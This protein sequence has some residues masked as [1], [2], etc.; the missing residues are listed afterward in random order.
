[1][2]RVTFS[3]VTLILQLS[4]AKGADCEI[5][6]AAGT[7]WREV[8]QSSLR[9]SEQALEDLDKL[10]S[11]MDAREWKNGKPMIDQMSAEEASAFERLRGSLANRQIASLIPSKRERDILA[12]AQMASIAEKFANR[13]FE[14]P[15]DENSDESIVA[16]FLLSIREHFPIAA[17]ESYPNAANLSDCDLQNA[18]FMKADASLISANEYPFFEAAIDEMERLKKEYPNL[19]KSNEDMSERD[20]KAKR[21]AKRII[22]EAF[23]FIDLADDYMRLAYL[24]EASKLLYDASMRDLFQH[25]GEVEKIGTTWKSWAD[26][27]RLTKQQLKAAALLYALNEIIPA[28]VI[29]TYELVEIGQEKIDP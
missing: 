5:Q 13:E 15:E 21:E 29:K 7:Q 2:I 6:K 18:L 20:R 12:I 23:N 17:N 11:L 26:D 28:D 27:G 10:R 9:I 3:I 1:M 14:W 4:V 25:P 22:S 19:N 16:S 24:E 8:S